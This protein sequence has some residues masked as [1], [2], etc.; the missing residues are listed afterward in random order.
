[1]ATYRHNSQPSVTWQF[2][3]TTSGQSNFDMRPHYCC[4]IV[5]SYSP[6]GATVHIHLTRSSL[7]PRV[8]LQNGISISWGIFAGLTIVPKTQTA[9]CGTSYTSKDTR[10]TRNALILSGGR[11]LSRTGRRR[12]LTHAPRNYPSPGQTYAEGWVCE[13]ANV[14]VCQLAAAAA[15]MVGGVFVCVGTAP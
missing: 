7:N 10:L 3:A 9:K 11:G 6:G 8:S 4:K 1:M 15:V 13:W 12:R 14:G 2:V 5:P